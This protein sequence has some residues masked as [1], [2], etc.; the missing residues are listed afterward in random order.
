MV[1]IFESD[2]DTLTTLT[3]L[4]VRV[5]DDDDQQAELLMLTPTVEVSLCKMDHEQLG[6]FLG[7]VYTAHRMMHERL[8]ERGEEHT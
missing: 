6:C 1:T 2:N 5:K 8:T 3:R 4:R 7:T